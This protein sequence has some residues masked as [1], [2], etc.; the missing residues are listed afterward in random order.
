[1]KKQLHL[2]CGL[3]A[4]C[5][6]VSVGYA[7]EKFLMS[8]YH[9]NDP[10]MK[11]GLHYFDKDGNNITHATGFNP[12]EVLGGGPEYFIVASDGEIVGINR[13][14]GGNENPDSGYGTLYRI[15]STGVKKVQ[16]FNYAEG[17]HTFITQA[18]DGKIYGV[19]PI[20]AASYQ[21]LYG[22]KEAGVTGTITYKYGITGVELTATPSGAVLGT[23]SIG[24]TNSQ[25]YIFRHDKTSFTTIYS[26]S[27]VTGHYPQGKLLY[28]QDGYIY[29]VTKRGG[30]NDFGVIY[31]IKPDGTDYKVIFHFNSNSGKYPLHRMAE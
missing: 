7:Q 12:E 18:S 31:K 3:L 5:F 15:T 13:T 25:G 14:G 24:G 26:F 17:S 23:A 9:Y 21:A 27:K 20:P 30:Q 22:T 19:G 8:V 4:L 10:E 28:G 6:Y 2:V 16:D 11:D 1:M 29:G